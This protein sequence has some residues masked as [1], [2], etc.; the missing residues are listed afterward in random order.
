LYEK[1]GIIDLSILDSVMEEISSIISPDSVVI[2]KSTA[3]PGTTDN[4]ME[5]HP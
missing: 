5:K 1:T 4:Y 2:I 3:I